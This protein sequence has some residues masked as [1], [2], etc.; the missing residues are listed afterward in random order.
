MIQ[1][2]QWHVSFF[3]EHDVEYVKG[4]GCEYEIQDSVKAE[5]FTS[6]N[7]T[8][9]RFA[10]L[11][12]EYGLYITSKDKKQESL[13]MLKYSGNINLLRVFYLEEREFYDDIEPYV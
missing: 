10:A 13:L 12:R 5:E 11:S 9:W 1:I 8:R 6:P 7:G 2:K 4:L 3:D